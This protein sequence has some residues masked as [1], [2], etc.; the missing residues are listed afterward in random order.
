[1]WEGGGGRE[2]AGGRWWEAGIILKAWG[3]RLPGG[4]GR[5]PAGGRGRRSA[6]QAWCLSAV[7]ARAAAAHAP[8]ARQGM[9]SR[10]HTGALATHGVCSG[11][12]RRAACEGAIEHA[13]MLWDVRRAATPLSVRRATGLAGGRRAEAV[14]RG[15]AE[16][17]VSRSTVAVLERGTAAAGPEG[18]GARRS[19][20][21]EAID[22]ARGLWP[23]TR[24]TAGCTFTTTSGVWPGSCRSRFLSADEACADSGERA[25][26]KRGVTRG[27]GAFVRGVQ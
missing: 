16:G 4:T 8:P 27:G 26:V 15:L 6:L 5:A 25:G 9:R 10:S 21:A 17:L 18:A 3:V 20:A 22:V 1:M 7:G 2:V 12:D 14:G 13:A 24:T 23:P 19:A 11:T